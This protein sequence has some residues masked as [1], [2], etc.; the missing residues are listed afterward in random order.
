MKI[1]Q[2]KIITKLEKATTFT[3]RQL[4]HTFVYLSI[5]N[6]ESNWPNPEITV[7]TLQQI[8]QYDKCSII[9]D[10]FQFTFVTTENHY[11]Y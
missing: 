9:S 5:L 8:F 3:C 11:R 6:M 1:K 2:F 10:L 4:L 7:I